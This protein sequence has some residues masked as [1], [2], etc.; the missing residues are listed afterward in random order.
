MDNWRTKQKEDTHFWV[1]RRL[2]EKPDITQRELAK[3]LGIS[4]GGVNYCLQDL[5]EKGWVKMQNFSHSKNKF[6]YAYF[7]LTPAGVAEKAAL[8]CGSLGAK[9]LNS[10]LSKQK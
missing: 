2:Q 3:E 6:G 5:M 1:M 8:Q 4:L 9:W 10:M 7:L